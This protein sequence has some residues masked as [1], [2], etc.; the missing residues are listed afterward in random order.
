MTPRQ[1]RAPAAWFRLFAP[2]ARPLAITRL[3]APT[4]LK[5]CLPTYIGPLSTLSRP[6]LATPRQNGAPAARFRLFVPP[7]PPLAIA[8]LCGPTSPTVS[9]PAYIIPLST[10]SHPRLGPPRQNRAPAARF[11]LC[12]L[13]GPPPR[14]RTI[15]CT[16]PTQGVFTHLYCT[17]VHPLPPSLG[18]SQ[19]KPSPGGSRSAFCTTR[20]APSRSP[21][22]VHQSRPK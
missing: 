3:R 12:A 8:R 5:A 2:Q 14:D 16:N 18:P 7:G 6:R 15:T 17:P 10:L 4:P 1:N 11:R 13:P 20:P 9:L 19:T 22:Y 21:D